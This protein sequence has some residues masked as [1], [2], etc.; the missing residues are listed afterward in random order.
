MTDSTI[1]PVQYGLTLKTTAAATGYFSADPKPLP[2]FEA[3]LAYQRRCPNDSFMRTYLLGLLCAMDADQVIARLDETPETDLLFRSLVLEAAWLS[4]HLEPLKKRFRSRDSRRLAGQSPLIS[5]R[6]AILGDQALHQKWAAL[7]HSNFTRHRPLPPPEK[8]G[9]SFPVPSVNGHDLLLPESAHL[10]SILPMCLAEKEALSKGEPRP[11]LEETLS[12]ALA[13]L[14]RI[15]VFD[16]PEMRHQSSLSPCALLRKWRF[17]RDI[18]CGA[19]G[20]TLSGTQTSYGRGVSVDKA[21]VSCLMEVVERYS[22][23]AGVDPTHV[24][25]T[26]RPHPLVHGSL[27]SL[28][29]DGRHVLDPNQLNLEVPYRD[30]PLYWMAGEECTAAGSRDIWVPVQCVFL[31]CNLDERTLFSGLGSTGLASGNTIAEARL[32]ALYELLERDSEAVSPYHFSRCFRIWAKN[33]KMA[34]LLGDYQARGIHVQFQDISPAFGIPVCTAFVTGRDGTVFRGGG[35]HL[36]G[37]KAVLS[38]L[39]E[40]PY[41]YP[42]GPPSAPAI[43]DLPWLQYEDLP[44]FSTGIP[45]LD[46]QIV[47]KTL[48]ANGF[49]P[50]Y[51]DITRKDLDI[52]VVRAIIPG[53]EIM[54]DFDMYTRISPRLF[55][56]YLK[57]FKT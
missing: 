28:R 11:L 25:E 53:F 32:S 51:V 42:E 33:E 15:S 5:L 50:I 44:D 20:Y 26:R 47:E 2:S 31:F 43:P 10:K 57:M 36:D 29:S 23:F 24:R 52:P 4:P 30:E 48:A 21:R 16:G 40:I 45:D 6:S 27:S 55:N 35:A 38:A 54:A 17:S 7:F 34:A 12:R 41:P 13:A 22:S 18:D 9:L 49:S 3:A 14:S 39:T 1:F 37:K 56:T 8:T 46:L 19:L